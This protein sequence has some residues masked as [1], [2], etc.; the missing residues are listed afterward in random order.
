MK[1]SEL[2]IWSTNDLETVVSS[3]MLG[4]NIHFKGDVEELIYAIPEIIDMI[5]AFPPCT[6]LC[7][8][9]VQHLFKEPGRLKKMYKGVRLFNRI[10]DHPCEKIAIENPI[11]HGYAKDRI[12]VQQTQIIQPWMF[13]HPR[14]KSTCLWLKGLPKLVETNNVYE[15]MLKLPIKEQKE[16]YLM[17]KS[18]DRSDKRSRLFQ[19]IGDAMSEQWG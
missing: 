15:E 4:G 11:M 8:T 12:G 10:K 1:D 2:D 18:K 7:N 14:R 5:I 19:G 17:G 3:L 13:G 9:G 6:Y 16:I